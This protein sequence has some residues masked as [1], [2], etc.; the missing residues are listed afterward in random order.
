MAGLDISSFTGMIPSWLFNPFIYITILIIIPGIFYGFLLL[1]KRKKLVYSVV[2]I[3]DLGEGKMALNILGDKSAGW[4]GKTIKFNGLWDYGDPKVMRLKTGEI[5]EKFD[6]RYFHE[7]NGKRGIVVFRDPSNRV[8]IP[9]NGL[10]QE[11]KFEES[12][13]LH[14]AESL[15]VANRHVLAT[16]APN[17]YSSTSVDIVRSA[18]RE[19]ADKNQQILHTIIVIS[20]IVLGLLAILFITHFA[21]QSIDK[22]NTLATEG[23][24]TCAENTKTIC[25]SIV[26]QYAKPSPSNVP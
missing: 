20:I 19:T 18:A 10:E 12:G 15:V 11:Y 25:E 8:L 16:L 1:R 26:Q 5:I 23:L 13:K 6:E 21:G 24:K 4:F 2:E 9:V 3:V 17:D 7:I 22:A 14:A